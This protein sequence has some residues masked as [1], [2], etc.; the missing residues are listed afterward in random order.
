M[1]KVLDMLDTEM[2]KDFFRWGAP[3]IIIHNFFLDIHERIP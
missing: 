3:F 1:K 2:Y